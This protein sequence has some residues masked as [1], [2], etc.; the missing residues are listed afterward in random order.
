MIAPGM[1]IGPGRNLRLL[2]L[3]VFVSHHRGAKVV[4]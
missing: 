1:S 4:K 3:Q 2:R